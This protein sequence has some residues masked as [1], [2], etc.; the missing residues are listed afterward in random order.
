MGATPDPRR[1]NAA[2]AQLGPAAG[3]PVP[4][5]RRCGMMESL[6]SRGRSEPS[7]LRAYHISMMTSRPDE[8][9]HELCDPDLRLR[10]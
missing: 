6:S 2:A 5:I 3:R 4:E 1:G 8:V 9:R 10:S 7:T